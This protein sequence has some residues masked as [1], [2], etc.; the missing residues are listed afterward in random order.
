MTTSIYPPPLGLY[1][2]PQPRPPG[3]GG[4]SYLQAYL[5]RCHGAAGHA[6]PSSIVGSGRDV[7]ALTK[8]QQNVRIFLTVGRGER[9]PCRS[10][11]LPCCFKTQAFRG[12]PGTPRQSFFQPAAPTYVFQQHFFHRLASPG[13]FCVATPCFDCNPNPFFD[14]N[15]IFQHVNQEGAI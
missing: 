4:D 5:E 9:S 3:P 1:A 8:D 11:P 15:V 10:T 2:H 13:G 6:V 14:S 12:T 7:M